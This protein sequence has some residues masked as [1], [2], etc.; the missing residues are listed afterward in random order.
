MGFEVSGKLHTKFEAKQITER[1]RKR[2]FVIEIEDGRYSQLVLFQ[3]TGLTAVAYLISLAVFQLGT[4]V[5]P[6]S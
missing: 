5:S 2:E 1:F 3:L 4:L 6:W